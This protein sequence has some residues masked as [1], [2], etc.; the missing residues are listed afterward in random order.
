MLKGRN[1]VQRGTKYYAVYCPPMPVNLVG[2]R[3]STTWHTNEERDRN[4]RFILLVVPH[5]VA[6]KMSH[7]LAG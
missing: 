3:D 5:R 7:R 6:L 2:F 4:G 1:N